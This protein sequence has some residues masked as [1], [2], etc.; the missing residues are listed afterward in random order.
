MTRIAFVTNQRLFTSGREVFSEVASV[1]RELL[2][3]ARVLQQQ[4]HDARL[5]SLSGMARMHIREELDQAECLVFGK[6]Y[7]DPQRDGAQPFSS[8]AAA[9]DGVLAQRREDQHVY[10]CLSDDHF[11]D[12]RFAAFYRSAAPMSRCW[13]VSSPAIA[14]RLRECP[15]EVR[16]FPEPVEMPRGEPHV[17]RRGLR[18]RI[19]VAVARQAKVGLD[20]WRMRL[21]WFGHP[22]N[23]PS[24][25][26]VLPEL[27]AL[28][29]DV[30]LHLECVTHPG[31][32]LVA[33]LANRD[34][35]FSAPLKV[36]V[37]AWSLEATHD[38]LERCDAV[39][40]PQLADSASQRAKSNNRLIDS[41][42]AG[43]FAVAHPLPAYAELRDYAW[44]GESI[45][46]GLRWLLR[47]P[48][49]ALARLKRGQEYVAEHHSREA[50][51]KFWLDAL[52]LRTA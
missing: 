16:V 28:A 11:Q 48:D 19:A 26:A 1:R 14:Q 40:L 37:S 34:A 23:L 49:E 17:P 43:R 24:L 5:V 38:A 12:A 25:L 3:P 45:E 6:I 7:R 42:H 27:E 30:P 22:S 51:G 20:P 46:K 36:M 21:A 35:G 8:D 13:I 15:G 52:A 9:Y 4:G 47:H 29:R 32:E 39:L 33:E 18:H 44:V 10:F 31:A 2:L 41:L 50:F